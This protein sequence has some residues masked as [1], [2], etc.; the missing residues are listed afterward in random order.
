MAA[1]GMGLEVAGPGG[2]RAAHGSPSVIIRKVAARLH[3]RAASAGARGDGYPARRALNDWCAQY[4][5]PVC[6]IS[7]DSSMTPANPRTSIQRR[8]RVWNNF[9]P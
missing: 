6:S 3:D 4:S 7:S 1:N 9:G 2:H 8:R 5:L